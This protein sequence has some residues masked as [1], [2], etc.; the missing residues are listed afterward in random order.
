M[1]GSSA[2]H[3][4]GATVENVRVDHGGFDVFAA[5]QVLNGSDVLATLQQLGGE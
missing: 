2:A 4:N 1:G 3:A 5:H